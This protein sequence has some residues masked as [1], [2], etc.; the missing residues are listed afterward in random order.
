[1]HCLRLQNTTN[2]DSRGLDTSLLTNVQASASV[3]SSCRIISRRFFSTS[4]YRVQVE[5]FGARNIPAGTRYFRN[6]RIATLEGAYLL[7]SSR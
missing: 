7:I 4:M 2:Y 3:F 5:I 6:R 1:M